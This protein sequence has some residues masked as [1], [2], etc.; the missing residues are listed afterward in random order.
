MVDD[1]VARVARG[2]QDF[3]LGLNVVGGLNQRPAA[4]R[5]RHDDVGKQQVDVPGAF[6]QDQSGRSVGRTEHFVSELL[7]RADDAETQALVVLDDEYGLVAG[8]GRRLRWPEM[9]GGLVVSPEVELDARAVPRLAVDLGVAAALSDE[10]VDHAETEPRSAALRLRRKEWIDGAGNSLRRHAGSRVAEDDEDV[11]SW[12]YLRMSGGV[13]VVEHDIGELDRQLAPVIHR[14]RGIE[15]EVEYR[16]FELNRVEDGA[17]RAAAADELDLDRFTDGS[18][19]QLDD[20]RHRFAE[21]HDFLLERLLAGI[22]HQ[23]AND[24]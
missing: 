16:R 22:S 20:G 12:H 7:E 10:A 9:L 21:N 1:R 2:E 8:R 4:D 5:P 15:R 14:V 11:L 23:L 18:A 19:N 13:G 17:P 3:Y 24:L 6:K